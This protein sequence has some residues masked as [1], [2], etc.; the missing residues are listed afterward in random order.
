[1]ILLLDRQ[2][3]IIVAEL[4]N[5]GSGACPYYDDL[6]EEKLN[7]AYRTYTFTVPANHPDSKYVKKNAGVAIPDPEGD[8]FEYFVQDTEYVYSSGQRFIR[9]TCMSGHLELLGFLVRPFKLTATTL[10][11]ALNYFLQETRWSIGIVEW[12]GVKDFATADYLTA[13]EAIH[14]LRDEFKAELRFRISFTGP[15]ITKRLVDFLQKRGTNHGKVAEV[16]KDVMEITEKD[17]IEPYTA[18]VGV[19]KAGTDGKPL[20]FASV[21]ASDKP[22]GQDWI[23]DEEARIKFGINGQHKT[24]LWV[25]PGDE[26]ITAAEL[27]A[28]TRLKLAEVVKPIYSYEAKIVNLSRILGL[29]HESLRIGDSFYIKDFTKDPFL[30]L[31]V[32]ILEFKRSQSDPS[33]DECVLGEYRKLPTSIDKRFFE[34]QIKMLKSETVQGAQEKANA[35]QVAA[36]SAAA[37]DA[38]EKAATAKSEAISYTDNKLNDYVTASTYNIDISEIQDQIDGNITSWFYD[39]VPT[40]SNEPAN[41]WATVE[42]KNNH[43]GDLFYNNIT[44]YAYRFMVNDAVYSWTQIKDTDVTKALADAAAAQDA[45]DSKRRVFVVQP[46]APYDV[47]DLWANGQTIYRAITSKAEGTSFSS[48]DWTKIGDVTSQNTAL[49]TTNVNGT[50]AAAVAT[51]AAAGK[52]A[53]DKIVAEV[54]SGTLE[55]TTGAQAKATAARTAAENFAK[56][57][58]NIA[59]GIIDVSAVALQ[60]AANGARIRWDGVN[61]LVQYD[62][63]GNTVMQLGLNGSAKFAGDISGSTGT[64]TGKISTSGTFGSVEIENDYI[65]SRDTAGTEIT[66]ISSGKVFAYKENS[67]Y[68]Y[69]GTYYSEMLIYQKTKK[70]SGK[71]P[72][73][74]SVSPGQMTMTQRNEDTGKLLR[75][76]AYRPD[77]ANLDYYPTAGSFI[78]NAGTMEPWGYRSIEYDP[79][80]NGKYKFWSNYEARMMETKEYN[81]AGTAVDYEVQV[82][83]RGISLI[84]TGVTNRIV[85]DAD[86]NLFFNITSGKKAD[87][88]GSEIKTTGKLSA[89]SADITGALTIAQTARITGLET[90][91]VGTSAVDQNI[92][93]TAPLHG[94]AVN[95]KNVKAVPPSSV[96]ITPTSQNNLNVDVIDIDEYGFWFYIKGAAGTAFRYWRGLY[97]A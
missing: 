91:K 78:Q 1:M 10:E 79:A 85:T 40:L 66:E 4:N 27:L 74:A 47:G 3:E 93:T 72:E 39:H 59:S 50:S 95:F 44:G 88:S 76:A 25:Y 58:S 20:T 6:D 7:D 80:V 52:T 12:S 24:G 90:G 13:I 73:Y 18:L 11:D 35:A 82:D 16:T 56:N 9:A 65:E 86:G 30:L 71:I 49:D 29:E 89:G 17:S 38:E 8:F 64:F 46:V 43:L 15:K 75:S 81:A 36:V 77:F 26:T 2:K 14:L 31:E 70:S 22:L 87:F 53:N 57:A 92:A 97:T 51:G 5:D 23:G 37:L 48:A 55:T 67:T 42:E 68:R 83:P 45:A 69:D 96:S 62:A 28:K 32:R 60:T 34:M 19:G 94:Y 54:G 41:L 21:S 33:K 61:G 84:R 63:A